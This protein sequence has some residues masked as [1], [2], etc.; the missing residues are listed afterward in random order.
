LWIELP[1]GTDAILLYH[2]ALEKGIS[3]VPGPLFSLSGKYGH[4]IRLSAAQWDERIEQGIK[5]LG[6]LAHELQPR[7]ANR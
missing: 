1:E 5:T 3:I 6:A 2:R 7:C 4:H